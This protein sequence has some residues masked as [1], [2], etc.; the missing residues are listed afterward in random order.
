MNILLYEWNTFGQKDLEESLIRLGCKIDKIKYIFTDFEKDEAF[1]KKLSELFLLKRYD[2]VISFNFFQ[3][4]SKL[5]N[6]FCIKYIAWVFDSPLL[7]L[8]STAIYHPFNYIFIFDGTLYQQMKKVLHADTVYYLPMAVNT[9]RLDKLLEAEGDEQKYRAEVSF[10]GKLYEKNNHYDEISNLPDYLT[11]YFDGIM[12]AQMKIYGYN[13]IK[14]MLTDPIMEELGRYIDIRPG[15]NFVGD[16]RDIFADRFLN[17][18]IT[19]LERKTMLR[20][21]SEHYDVT[22]YTG[23]DSSDLPKVNNRGYVDYYKIM[24]LIFRYSKINLN[25]TLRTIK[26]GIPLRVFDILGAGGF[27]ITNYQSDIANYFDIGEDLV[28]YE[29]EEDLV[30]KVGYY[31][32]HEEERKR[33]AENGYRK[34]KQFHNYE[35]RLN[36]IFRIASE[37]AITYTQSSGREEP[38]TVSIVRQVGELVWEG[39]IEEAKT[40]YFAYRRSDPGIDPDNTF[41]NLDMIFQ[42]HAYEKLRGQNTLFD[43]SRELKKVQ[44][45]YD[46]LKWLLIRLEESLASKD[47][48][49]RERTEAVQTERNRTE[50]NLA[51]EKRTD[52]DLTNEEQALV[53]Y[54]ETNQVSYT[55]IEFIINRFAKHKVELLNRVAW[56]FYNSGMNELVLPFLSQAIEMS[57]KDDTTLTHL[58]HILY[59]LGEY[60]MAYDY[61]NEIIIASP[62]TMVLMENILKHI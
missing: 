51:D 8:N 22:L 27:L 54:V 52:G 41:A 43:Y 45:H 19:G 46:H 20:S 17:A 14:E 29:S 26:S 53:R 10:V 3:V 13:F 42:I 1:E 5:C 44:E 47:P 37:R 61:I 16:V 55:A 32:E 58:A 28:C 40:E 23:S 9:G 25:M 7:N 4:I 15:K 6:S 24:P 31:L 34:V 59:R 48:T 49:D 21:L 2:Y 62:E 60:Q 36:E 38:D 11:G 18:K 39:R 35:V 57:P 56:A 12:R 50:G 30:E 33:I